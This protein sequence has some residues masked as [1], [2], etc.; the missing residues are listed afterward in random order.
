MACER[1]SV[2]KI[3]MQNDD[4]VVSA[5]DDSSFDPTLIEGVTDFDNKIWSH[6][7]VFRSSCLDSSSKRIAAIRYG[8]AVDKLE[9]RCL[10][11]RHGTT[12]RT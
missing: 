10:D 1:D 6:K 5:N 4:S 7:L 9:F 12:T 11:E 2:F 3:G 8:T